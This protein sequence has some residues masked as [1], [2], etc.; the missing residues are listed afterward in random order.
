MSEIRPKITVRALE[1]YTVDDITNLM[2]KIAGRIQFLRVREYFMLVL[3][4]DLSKESAAKHLEMSLEEFESWLETW[5]FIQD[6]LKE[7]KEKE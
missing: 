5:R 4:G 2:E 6:C 7:R 1:P 3:C